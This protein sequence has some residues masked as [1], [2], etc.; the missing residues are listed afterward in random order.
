MTIC[1]QRTDTPGFFTSCDAACGEP[2]RCAAQVRAEMEE[3][4]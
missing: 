3:S 4:K 1:G 2:C